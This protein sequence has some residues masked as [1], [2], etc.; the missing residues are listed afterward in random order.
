MLNPLARAFLDAVRQP[1]SKT[2]PR[3]LALYSNQLFD[4]WHD[5]RYELTG[6]LAESNTI[7]VFL[8]NVQVVNVNR[9]A[10]DD[11][12]GFFS[13]KVGI[14]QAFLSRSSSTPSSVVVYHDEIYKKITE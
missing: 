2:L 12:S 5:I 8:N 13:L 7:K 10:F 1:P 14:Y 9:A 4:T 6:G 3:I 11:E